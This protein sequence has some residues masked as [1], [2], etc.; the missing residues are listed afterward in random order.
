MNSNSDSAIVNVNIDIVKV[1]WGFEDIWSE[2][3]VTVFYAIN[4]IVLKI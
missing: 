4:K 3:D 2:N 1:D